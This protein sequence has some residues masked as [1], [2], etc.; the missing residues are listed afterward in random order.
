MFNYVCPLILINVPYP[1]N[2][3]ATVPEILIVKEN[4][5]LFPN[6]AVNTLTVAYASDNT[7]DLTAHIVTQD[8]V[9]LAGKLLY[10]NGSVFLNQFDVSELPPGKYF[11]QVSDGRRSI[12]KPFVK[13]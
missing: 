11:I 8:G 3:P 13:Q 5:S 4:L 2:T 1:T 12:A 9:K 10:D 7:Y 6:P